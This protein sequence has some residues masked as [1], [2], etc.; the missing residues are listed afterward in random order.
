MCQPASVVVLPISLQVTEPLFTLT[1][2]ITSNEFPNVSVDECSGSP[3]ITSSD[4]ALF[5]LTKAMTSNE[6][7]NVS[8]GECSGSP[9]S[10]QV[11]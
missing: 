4:R 3:H 8:A 2:A 6:F 5:T 1:K 10:L 11:T 9:I 7:P